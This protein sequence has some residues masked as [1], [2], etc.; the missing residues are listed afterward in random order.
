MI[1]SFFNILTNSTLVL[2]T[3]LMRT[4]SPKF[5][6]LRTWLTENHSLWVI[7]K[8]NKFML[9][10]RIWAFTDKNS[11]LRWISQTTPRSWLMSNHSTT[12]NQ[13]KDQWLCHK[14]T[15]QELVRNHW[16]TCQDLQ[17]SQ[18]LWSSKMVFMDHKLP[19]YQPLSRRDTSQEKELGKRTGLVPPMSKETS[20]FVSWALNLTETTLKSWRSMKEKIQRL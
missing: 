6:W 10:S 11:F 13:C 18:L 20:Q 19:E 14:T 5:R 4:S 15:Y 3:K 2:V 1:T 17:I 7:D 16:E 12:S 9:N 8:S